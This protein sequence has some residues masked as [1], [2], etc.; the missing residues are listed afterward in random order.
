MKKKQKRPQTEDHTEF[1]YEVRK[2][3]DLSKKTAIILFV[4]TAISF[5][6]KYMFYKLPLNFRNSH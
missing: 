4:V 5:F 1:S 6:F 3:S 2:R